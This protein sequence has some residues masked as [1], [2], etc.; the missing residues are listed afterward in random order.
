MQLLDGKKT[1]EDIKAKLQSKYKR[2][3]IMGESTSFSCS[4][5]GNDGASLTY[6]GSKVKA[7][8]R[9]GFESTLVKLQV[10]PLKPNCWKK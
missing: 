7:C 9:V 1:A 8:Q 6:V 5:M 10:L 4:V 3:K 2:W